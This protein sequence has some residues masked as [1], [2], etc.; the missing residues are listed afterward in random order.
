MGKGPV[1]EHYLRFMPEMVRAAKLL[2]ELV[3]QVV[4][5]GRLA[6]EGQG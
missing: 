3:Q 5:A 2:W 6:H 4:I 1:L